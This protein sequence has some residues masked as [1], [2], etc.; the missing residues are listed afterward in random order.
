MKFPTPQVTPL[1]MWMTSFMILSIIGSL[2][3]DL[4]GFYDI[5]FALSVLALTLFVLLVY[6]IL[7]S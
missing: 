4:T 1:I 7:R 2:I 5:S 3:T 6:I